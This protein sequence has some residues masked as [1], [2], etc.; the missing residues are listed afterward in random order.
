LRG[1]IERIE[2]HGDAYMFDRVALGHIDADA[3]LQG[4]L[5]IGAM[6]E[7]FAEGR[8]S[9][10]ATGFIVGLAGRVGLAAFGVGTSGFH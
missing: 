3:A 4:G 2:A 9:A 10:A 1:G 8:Q 5:A 6:H 7:V